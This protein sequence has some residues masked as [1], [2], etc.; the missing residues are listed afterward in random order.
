ML[1]LASVSPAGS[2][3][4]R[5]DDGRA[6]L[7]GALAD[8]RRGN[9]DEAIP[10][11]R[12]AELSFRQARDTSRSGAL[13]LAGWIP[14]LGRNVDAVEAMARAG[15]LTASAG[16]RVAR[17]L[18]SHQGGPQ[19]VMPGADR[20]PV[21]S[22]HALASS[23]SEADAVMADAVS[24]LRSAPG[25]WLLPPLG[26][27]RETALET[28]VPV[29]YAV[30]TG[31]TLV[32]RLPAFFGAD[33]PRVYLFGAENPAELRGTG[34]L[35]GA[36]ALLRARDG[37]VSLSGFR[38][39][40]SLPLLR[41]ADVEPPNDDY[42]RLYDPYRSGTG[43]WLNTNMTPDFPSAARAYERAYE[44]ATRSRIDGVIAADP[45]AFEAL[46]A[47]TG[48]A[49]VP[50]LGRTLAADDIVSFVTNEAYAQ[51]DD[52]A[53]RK[54]VLGSVARSVLTR[55]L[56]VGGGMEDLVALLRAAS[57][58][59]IHV[60]A[61]DPALQGA[62]INTGAGGRFAPSVA[63][64][65]LSVVQNN[66]GANK[67]DFYL[68]RSVEYVVRMDEDGDAAASVDIELRND[69]PT[70][71]Q[72]RYVLGPNVPFHRSAGENTSLLNVY[73]GTCT[74]T[75]ATRNSDAIQPVSG[76]ELGSTFYQDFLTI[77]SGG[78]ADVHLAYRVD[79]VWNGD[80]THGRY[81]FVFDDRTLIRGTRLRVEIH[82]PPG[83][84]V[85]DAPD[86]ASVG[87]DTVVWQGVP[88]GD[89]ELDVAF[90]APFPQRLW[91]DVVD[92]FGD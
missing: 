28:L 32:D 76:S 79:G 19:A 67:V 81:R 83:T 61:D 91:L 16:L 55:F 50:E 7:E 13:S 70:E 14:I 80:R 68:D 30:R 23:L 75:T 6:A 4:H 41:P 29:A 85:V 73:C 71:G 49:F 43:F 20:I 57:E 46:L 88:N 58:G 39:I 40:Q 90:A 21:P 59:H 48:P 62:L 17:G 64:D 9:P 63:G 66:A 12:A 92:L 22:L 53:H 35:I 3:R 11:L 47:A 10:R 54:S 34:G 5:L 8:L 1:G 37:V 87:G 77:P 27:A 69:A 52:P 60:F 42:R 72:P 38:P 36:Y 18:S 45:F 26:D 65:F 44:T 82:V 15:Q 2:V 33:G 24:V 25:T 51:F 74:L 89:L 84:E 78:R 86:D 31:A 56:A